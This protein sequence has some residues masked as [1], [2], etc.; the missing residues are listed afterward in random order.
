MWDEGQA[1]LLP[2]A[3][4][5]AVHSLCLGL[6][7]CESQHCRDWAGEQSAC[8]GLAS[9]VDAGVAAGGAGSAELPPSGSRRQLARFRMRSRRVALHFLASVCDNQVVQPRR[10][11]ASCSLGGLQQGERQVLVDTPALLGCVGTQ[12]HQNLHLDMNFA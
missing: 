3:C 1:V 6:H 5:C 4:K 2:E 11:R 10:P 9:G 8:P 7:N 12:L